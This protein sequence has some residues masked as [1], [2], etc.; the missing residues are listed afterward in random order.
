MKYV[1]KIGYSTKLVFANLKDATKALEALQSGVHVDETH[2][3]ANG[4]YC[5]VYFIAKEREVQLLSI[6]DDQLRATK[7]KVDN[8]GN[9][10]GTPDAVVMKRAPRRRGLLLGNGS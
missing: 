5:S 4:R 8:D 1:I 3:T 10:I 7:P 6:Y 2:C 9:E